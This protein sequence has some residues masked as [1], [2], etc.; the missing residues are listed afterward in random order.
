MSNTFTIT[1]SSGAKEDIQMDA[2]TVDQVANQVFGLTMEAAAEAGCNV[3]L[4]GPYVPE[5]ADLTGTITEFTLDVPCV[6]MMDLEDQGQL[7]SG[8][9]ITLEA[10][11][12]DDDAKAFING[13]E[14]TVLSVHPLVQIDLDLTG[15]VVDGLTA[16]Y[17]IYVEPAAE[18]EAA[19]AKSHHKKSKEDKAK[20]AEIVGDTDTAPR[21]KGTRTW[22]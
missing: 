1:Y 19:P 7:V 14:V 21:K 17:L 9:R 2:E 6:A 3:E 22:E 18:E 20:D 10:L 16:D 8:G 4:V 5:P 15:Y 12:G 13:K 11:T